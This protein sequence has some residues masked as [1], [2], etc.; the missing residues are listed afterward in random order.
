MKTPL[1]IPEGMRVCPVCNGTGRMEADE[2]MKKYKNVIAGY[3]L[4][5]DTIKCNNCGGQRMFGEP[6]GY[7]GINRDGVGC[8]H[9]YK[10]KTVGNCLTKYT[11][12][13]CGDS[14]EI[15]SSD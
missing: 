1:V 9:S 6:K 3:D 4:S 11:C 13:H 10:S 2:H 15:D 5:D 14:Y 8:T 7:V 12:E